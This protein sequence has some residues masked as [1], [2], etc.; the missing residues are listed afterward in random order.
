MPGIKYLKA[1]STGKY[2][3]GGFVWNS[4]PMH[5]LPLYSGKNQEVKAENLFSAWPFVAFAAG[6][7]AILLRKNAPKG[8]KEAFA[9]EGYGYKWDDS[10]SKNE[11]MPFCSPFL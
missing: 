3:G 6:T 7:A 5:I 4:L 10:K 11:S 1:T 8:G 2:A 9:G